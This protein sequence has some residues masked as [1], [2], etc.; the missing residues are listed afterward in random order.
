MR[1]LVLGLAATVLCACQ[2]ATSPASS[3]DPVQAAATVAD[4]AAPAEPVFDEAAFAAMEAR[5]LGQD[6]P[7][8][9]IEEFDWREVTCNFLGGEIGGDPEQDRAV[10][11]RLDELRC[12]DQNADA[13][14]LRAANAGD[15]EMV[16]RIDAYLARHPD[17]VL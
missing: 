15:A 16:A 5:Y 17:P 7:S 10:N 4:S 9:P 1:F 6:R 3:E 8:D 12:G 14:A 11:A 13:R 2:P